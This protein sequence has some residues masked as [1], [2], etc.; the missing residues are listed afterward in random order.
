MLFK[1]RQDK[2]ED[3]TIDYAVTGLRVTAKE[4]IPQGPNHAIQAGTEGTVNGS[5][6][7]SMYV[8]FDGQ[9][10]PTRCKDGSLIANSED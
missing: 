10:Q 3:E 5:H 9:H 2:L 4:D 6:R 1:N 7:D 8:T